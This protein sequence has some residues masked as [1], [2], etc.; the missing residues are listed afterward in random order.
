MREVRTMKKVYV[1]VTNDDEMRGPFL[2]VTRL[3]QL[4][5]DI[6]QKAM[7]LWNNW[8]GT[9][10]MNEKRPESIEKLIE[11]MLDDVVD[12]WIDDKC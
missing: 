1:I 11:A 2:D 5:D 12:L 8:K 3:T 7:K 4:D 6:V 10:G 9:E